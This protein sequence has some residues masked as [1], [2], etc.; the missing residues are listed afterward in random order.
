MSSVF[1]FASKIPGE[2]GAD[3]FY[4][5]VAAPAEYR[6]TRGREDHECVHYKLCPKTSRDVSDSAHDGAERV[7]LVLMSAF[8]CHRC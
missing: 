8:R 3:E 7:F 2:D 4:R 5:M 6:D 1:N